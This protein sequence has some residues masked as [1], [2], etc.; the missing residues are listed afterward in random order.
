MN[1]LGLDFGTT[2]VK[3][4]LFDENLCELMSVSEDYKLLASGNTVEIEPERYFEL[5]LNALNKIRKEYTV[6]CLAIDTQC[7][8]MIVAD[9]SGNPLRNAIVWLDNRATE[10]AQM[11]DEKFGRKTVY[12]VTGQPEIT[13]TWPASK[14]IWIKRN[15]PEV[16]SK[17]KKVFLLE[18]YLLYRLT[19]RF[20]TEK[21]LQS[22]SLYFDIRNSC[23]Y[24][25]CLILSAFHKICC[26]ILWIAA[27]MSELMRAL[28]L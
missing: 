8:T 4:V 19:G 21:T 2:S 26:R 16:F 1:C 23:W 15:E 17:I 25:K 11:I 22:S 13:A 7:E 5:L 27:S 14:L 6:D 18:D 28:K 3:A 24:K 10:E 20:V 9:E 12:E